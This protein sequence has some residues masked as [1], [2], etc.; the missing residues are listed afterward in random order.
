M[1]ILAANWKMF[2]TR[3]ECRQFFKNVTLNHKKNVRVI[4]AT[5]PTLLETAA[6]LAQEK[7]IS[8]FSQ[9][10]AWANE[11]AFTGEIA[12]KQI[13]EL[14]VT[15][16]LIGHSERRQYFGESTATCLK[17]IL[18]ALENDLEVIYC[19]GES[20]EER[21]ADKTLKVLAEQLKP[22]LSELKAQHKDK[23]MI[24]Y[25]P[26]WAIGTGVTASL[27]QIQ[28]THRGIID[29]CAEHNSKFPI[30]YGGSVKTDNFAA[31]ASFAEVSGGLVGGA[32]LDPKSFAALHE[33]LTGLSS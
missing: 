6:P 15:G 8:V 17:R 27:E 3:E 5:S 31:I 12:P 22:V 29:I 4:I 21:K 25:E 18:N 23:F 13:K 33:C 24:A 14:G 28:E 11:G 10:C 7:N 9:N 20:L 30:L 32:S 26:I 2:K 1:K 16:T 19:I